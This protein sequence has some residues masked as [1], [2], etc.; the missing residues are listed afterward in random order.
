MESEKRKGIFP[1]IVILFLLSLFLLYFLLWDNPFSQTAGFQKYSVSFDNFHDNLISGNFLPRWAS[2]TGRGYGYPLFVFRPP[3]VYW[4]G[5]IPRI[6]SLSPP[7]SFKIISAIS[8]VLAAVSFFYFSS[9]ILSKRGALLSSLIYIF[10][11]LPVKILS[12]QSNYDEIASLVLF[13]LTLFL[14]AGH[15]LQK[16]D[17]DKKNS[18]FPLTISMTALFLST[19]STKPCALSLLIWIFVF[20]FYTKD[21]SNKKPLYSTLCSLIASLA[22]S[23]FYWI[24]AICQKNLVY[25]KVEHTGALIASV[26]V[27]PLVLCALPIT[28]RIARK[29]TGRGEKIL[30]LTGIGTLS[31]VFAEKIF[32]CEIFFPDKD[33]LILFFILPLLSLLCGMVFHERKTAIK[34]VLIF[35]FFV[36]LIMLSCFTSFLQNLSQSQFADVIISP[37]EKPP[38]DVWQ[39]Y[40]PRSVKKIP[41]DKFV[42]PIKIISGRA[43]I[44]R[45]VYF[46]EKRGM[47]LK[48]GSEGC[49]I[50]LNLFNYPGWKISIK[51]LPDISTETDD[52]GRMFVNIPKGVYF[53]RI[54][55]HQQFT[56][57]LGALVSYVA[58]LIL[59][60]MFIYDKKPNFQ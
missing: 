31:L 5:E 39:E 32:S 13:P 11:P 49:R 58:L 8:I 17:S 2:E 3:L 33:S 59:F 34:S 43:K 20:S 23:S 47:R 15:L 6:F 29:N 30:L 7:L 42:F 57:N 48:T 50:R 56:D 19:T 37:Y 27:I 54:E 25:G 40:M 14:A 45:E 46:P 44:L 24:P 1:Y 4:I 9:L 12:F 60:L 52:T 28:L 35:I 18:F 10:S 21:T 36:A 38:F 26:G 53:L 51:E 22:L 41:E 55:Y 16:K